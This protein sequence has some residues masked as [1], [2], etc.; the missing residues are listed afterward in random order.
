[1]NTVIAR[2]TFLAKTPG[3][4]VFEITLEIGTPYPVEGE[5]GIWSCPVHM[6]ALNFDSCHVVGQGSLQ[7]LSMALMTARMALAS[8]CEKGGILSYAADS[9]EPIGDKGLRAIF[10]VSQ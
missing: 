8:F 7:A 5:D 1:M 3:E 6:P 9:G 4:P 10:G 2:E